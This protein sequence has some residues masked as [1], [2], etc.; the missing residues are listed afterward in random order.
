MSWRC[1]RLVR[2]R[3]D[4]KVAYRRRTRPAAVRA[5][6][7]DVH[8]ARAI[9]SRACC[10]ARR[11]YHFFTITQRQLPPAYKVGARAG[12][13]GETTVSMH[14]C[15]RSRA[16]DGHHGWPRSPAVLE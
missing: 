5:G 10:I 9:H 12:M 6:G 1:Y 4:D 11:L 13:A 3:A 14:E 16:P 15:S 2:N 8:G 7:V